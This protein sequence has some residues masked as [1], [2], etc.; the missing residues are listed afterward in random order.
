MW[1]VVDTRVLATFDPPY[2]WIGHAL[3]EGRHDLFSGTTKLIW[4]NGR[5]LV[6]QSD[7]NLKCLETPLRLITR[8]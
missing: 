2:I 1:K 8:F 7:A 3:S 4:M 6:A 5:L